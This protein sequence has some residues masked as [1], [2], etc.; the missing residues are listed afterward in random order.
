M[1]DLRNIIRQLAQPDG[2]TVSLV[3]TVDKVDKS[4]RTVDCSPINEGAPLLGVNLQANQEANYGF[5]LFPEVGSYV[6]VGFI[7]GGAA[8]VV[9][10]T[11]KIESAE[12][13]IG[14]TSAVMDSDG[15]RFNGGALGG[16]VKVEDLTKR[17]NIIEKDINQLKTVFATAWKPVAQDGGAALQTAAASWA[18]AK[19]TESMRGDYENTKVKH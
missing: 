9:L 12:I 2:E 17:L 8:G 15:V 3:C 6:V 18:G 16:L 19:L 5:C 14:D 4:A 13:V 1:A 7:S 11:E 10:L